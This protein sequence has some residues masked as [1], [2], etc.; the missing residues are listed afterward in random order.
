MPKRKCR[1][2]T[3]IVPKILLM[4]IHPNRA[5]KQYRLLAASNKLHPE[6]LPTNKNN[7][8]YAFN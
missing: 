5:P 2:L 1:N 7:F 3:A 4:A 8:N 6:T